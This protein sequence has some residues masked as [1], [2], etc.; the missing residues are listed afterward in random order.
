MSDDPKPNRNTVRRQTKG[1]YQRKLTPL[2]EQ[3]RLAHE[4]QRRLKAEAAQRRA[5]QLGAQPNGPNPDPPGQPPHPDAP[6]SAQEP[7]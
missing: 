1:R 3:G 6:E 2:E 5:E 4:H 7:V